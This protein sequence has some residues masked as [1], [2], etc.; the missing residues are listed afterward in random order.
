MSHETLDLR[1]FLQLV[2]RHKTVLGIFAA[3]GLF[4][5]VAFTVLRPPMLASE[6]L[7]VLT[8]GPA[9]QGVIAGSDPGS[10]LATQVVIAGSDPVLGSAL[11]RVDPA[12]SLQTLRHRLQVKSL[13]SNVLSI[14]AE[15]RTAAQ[16]EGTANAVADSYVAYVSSGK[17]PGG[18]VQARVLAPATT[19]AGTLLS[20]RLLITGGFGALLGVL[21]GAIAVFAFNRNDRRLRERDEIADSIGVP[22]LA[23]IRVDHPSNAAGW[24]KLFA[25]YEPGAVDAW[26]LR[27]ALQH[28]GLADENLNGS[29][30]G[31]GSS[32]AVLSFAFDPGAL[33]LG[34]QLAVFAASRGI[35]TTLVVGPQQDVN[36][37]ATL[38]AACAVPPL[39]PSRRSRHL[40][41][42]VRDHDSAVRPPDT[43]L[44][45]VVAVIDGQSPQVADTMRTTATVLGVSAG[46][47][48]AE[49]M[50]RVAASAAVG[51]RDITGILVADPDPVDPTTGRLPQLAR[52][53]QRRGPT[54]M[55][56]TTAETR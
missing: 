8:Q 7:V 39:A 55:T 22:V 48:T 12:I 3:L 46:A 52:S 31:S 20:F 29:K 14:R 43:M 19:A 47:A 6:S 41:V 37:T 10:A 56:G 26:R 42:I 33:A 9:I 24:T 40:Q 4:A 36:A 15:G 21:I 17:I 11:R 45:V 51:G 13:T 1:R 34:P 53:T 25:D 35:P 2:R 50:A 18:Q 23:S 38:R 44:T 28:L 27:K 32:L 54:R 5:G 16:A 49:Q 30:Q